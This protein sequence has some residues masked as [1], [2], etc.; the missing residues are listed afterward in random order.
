MSSTAAATASPPEEKKKKSK[1]PLIV[2]AAVLLLALAGA[3]AYFMLAKN[4]HGGDEEG[5]AEDEAAEV[6]KAPVFVNMEP[7]T[8]N[9]RPE[10]GPDQ[11]LQ[12]VCV[13]RVDAA[14]AGERIKQFMPEIRHRAILLLSGKSAA[15][16][17]TTQGREQ[18]SEALRSEINGIL[19]PAQRK[20]KNAGKAEDVVQT[21]LFT[22]FIIQ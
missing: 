10:N 5:F 2:G 12:A 13:L 9:L 8:V 18:L 4:D 7:I 19:S 21:V 22:S 16:I 20:G 1:L 14:E 3:G 11:Y 15:E 6:V 17:N